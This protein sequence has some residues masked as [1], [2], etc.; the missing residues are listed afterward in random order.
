MPRMPQVFG[1]A[2]HAHA[3]VAGFTKHA[4][5]PRHPRQRQPRGAREQPN[6]I[7]L[8]LKQSFPV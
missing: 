6:W 2:T 4:R 3:R 8:T 5:H 1:I 7:A